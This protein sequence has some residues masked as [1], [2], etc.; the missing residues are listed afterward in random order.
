[1]LLLFQDGWVSA[2]LLAKHPKLYEAGI[3]EETLVQL[4]Q[5]HAI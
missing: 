1:M 4:V 2:K 5:V 3:R